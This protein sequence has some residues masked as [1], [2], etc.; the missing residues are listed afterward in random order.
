MK[1]FIKLVLILLNYIFIAIG[2]F[3][4]VSYFY[5]IVIFSNIKIQ[6][7]GGI[8]ALVLAIFIS[9]I[10]IVIVSKKES[11][12]QKE[13]NNLINQNVEY[14]FEK[15]DD[16][17]E[18]VED[19]TQV[20]SF[21]NVELFDKKE[22]PKQDI[23]ETVSN[24]Q[25]NIDKVSCEI[26]EEVVSNTPNTTMEYYDVVN[27]INS[28]KEEYFD[29]TKIN[30]IDANDI[31]SEKALSQTAAIRNLDLRLTKTEQNYIENSELSY[32]NENGLPQFKNTSTNTLKYQNFKDYNE[33]TKIEKNRIND[34]T[35]IRTMVVVLGILVIILMIVSYIYF[36]KIKG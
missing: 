27:D 28:Q 4:F 2:C 6:L 30:L 36:R 3:G 14:E 22:N 5:N 15:E 31:A 19:L 26:G 17:F 25:L 23:D 8:G 35:V 33:N 32:I 13:D 9:I 10:L 11:I 7:Y 16:E 1:S 21:Q 20:I 34:D 12:E 24:L 18:N 29:E